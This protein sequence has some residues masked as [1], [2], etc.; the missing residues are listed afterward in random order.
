MINKTS[1]FIGTS[2]R[3]PV[4]DT[5]LN[6]LRKFVL[7]NDLTIVISSSH[8]KFYIDPKPL[9]KYL[10]DL[11]DRIHPD[12]KTPIDPHIGFRGNEIA[13]WMKNHPEVS[14]YVILDDCDDFYEY[15]PLV[16]TSMREGFGHYDESYL[17]HFYLNDEFTQTA[18]LEPVGVMVQKGD[19]LNARTPLIAH[20]CNAQG[21]MKSGVAKAIRASHPEAFDRYKSTFDKQGLKLGQVIWAMSDF[22]NLKGHYRWIANVITQDKFGYDEKLYVDYDALREGLTQVAQ[23]A[24]DRFGLYEFAIPKIGAGLGGG[25]WDI[26]YEILNEIAISNRINICVY[27]L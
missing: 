8:R 4:N 13:A 11:V 10:H 14:S 23:D 5:C 12:W 25:D 9:S 22:Y 26:I 27:E 6:H 21:K 15:Q 3:L 1:D 7:D 16:R 24:V 2:D 19:L 20:G 18:A 17:G